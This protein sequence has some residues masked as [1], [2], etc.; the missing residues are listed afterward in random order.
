MI[1]LIRKSVWFLHD[2]S[3]YKLISLLSSATPGSMICFFIVLI[4]FSFPGTISQTFLHIC[5]LDTF[6]EHTSFCLNACLQFFVVYAE[7]GNHWVIWHIYL[8]LFEE[9][10]NDFTHRLDRLIL[11]E[12]VFKDSSLCT[13]LSTLFLF[14]F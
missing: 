10:P 11:P 3:V 12:A 13:S 2:N 14:V 4:H 9:T 6:K 1:K 8:Q 7:E 5:H